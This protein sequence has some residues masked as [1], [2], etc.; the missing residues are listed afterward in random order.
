[1]EN[2]NNPQPTE[3]KSRILELIDRLKQT[4]TIVDDNITKK[5]GETVWP[6][7]SQLKD[8][9]NT[10]CAVILGEKSEDMAVVDMLSALFT[11][12]RDVILSGWSDEIT[13]K[14]ADALTF[15]EDFQKN[16]D[17]IAYLFDLA[18]FVSHTFEMKSYLETTEDEEIKS[19]LSELQPVLNTIENITAACKS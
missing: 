4:S 15:N 16:E 13:G 19:L 3:A 11:M 8:R 7:A 18:A 10:I 6:F 17:I 5:P 2:V 14:L 1:M 9:L 12:D